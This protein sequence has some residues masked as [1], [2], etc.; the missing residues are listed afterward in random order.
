M[1]TRSGESSVERTSTCSST[2]ALGF[3]P[4][5]PGSPIY[6]IGSPAVS[7]ASLRLEN[8]K[9]FSIEAKDQNEKNVYVKKI[10]L[11]GKL[12]NRLYLTHEEIMAGGKLVFYMSSKPV[13]Q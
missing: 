12:L 2:N 3:Y 5:A 7:A 9:Q 10:E 1:I 11:N 13:K 8:G 6:Q 4:V